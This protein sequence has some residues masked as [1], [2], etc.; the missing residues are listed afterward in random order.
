M[1]Y[2][3]SF[4]SQVIIWLGE[5]ADTQVMQFLDQVKFGNVWITEKSAPE[6]ARNMVTILSYPWWRR[7]WVLQEALLGR[8]TVIRVGDWES[9]F[10]HFMEDLTTLRKEITSRIDRTPVLVTL[11]QLHQE[12]IEVLQGVK[13][14]VHKRGLDLAADHRVQ[15]NAHV[16]FPPRSQDEI[17][18][19]TSAAWDVVK[20]CELCSGQETTDPRDKMYGLL[21]LMPESVWSVIAP[22]YRTSAIITQIR[23]L[24]KISAKLGSLYLLGLAARSSEQEVTVRPTW[25]PAWMSPTSAK[26]RTYDSMGIYHLRDSRFT[27]ARSTSPTLHPF[28]AS[29]GARDLKTRGI[30]IGKVVAA[31]EIISEFQ[32]MSEFI[33][34]IRASFYLHRRLCQQRVPGSCIPLRSE[35]MQR[36]PE[37]L[38]DTGFS[39]D[40]DGFWSYIP[41]RPGMMQ[42]L[43]ELLPD[44]AFSLDLDEI[45][46]NQSLSRCRCYPGGQDHLRVFWSA[47]LCDFRQSSLQITE[48]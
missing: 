43:I 45:H 5:S 7:L 44:S 27:A 30:L 48:R 24:V 39:L 12:T 28:Q 31:S 3:S 4:A 19:T 9:H 22:D 34:N 8:M 1:K 33:M 14:L 36:S 6:V 16:F 18:L 13:H 46:M 21:G 15:L 35:T 41:P 25:L 20:L 37:S 2:I 17:N 38:S 40:L 42:R 26:P 23:I 32:D 10:G 47:M 29:N 11:R